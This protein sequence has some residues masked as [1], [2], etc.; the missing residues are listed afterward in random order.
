MPKMAAGFFPGTVT[1]YP[2]VLHIKKLRTPT[3]TNWRKKQNAY[4]C[5][6]FEPYGTR[7]PAYFNLWPNPCNVRTYVVQAQAQLIICY[8]PVTF[9][10][11]LMTA[12]L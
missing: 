6:T 4:E 5:N 12:T 7:Q 9:M 8:A 1:R 3:E 10:I 11:F 2:W